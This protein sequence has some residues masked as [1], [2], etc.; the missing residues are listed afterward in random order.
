MEAAPSSVV[1]ISGTV[2]NFLGSCSRIQRVAVAVYSCIL[3]L[4]LFK[5]SY[6]LPN[7]TL[8]QMIIATIDTKSLPSSSLKASTSHNEKNTHNTGTDDDSSDIEEVDPHPAQSVKGWCY[9]GSH[10]FTPSAWGTLSGSAFNPV[11]NVCQFFFFCIQRADNT[12]NIQITNYEIGVIFPLESTEAANNIACWE[13]PPRKYNLPEE[14]AW[15]SGWHPEVVIHWQ[16][17]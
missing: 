1:E 12:M 13:R 14:R 6:V 7:Q 11:L 17:C 8:N 9:I 15:V 16:G 4:E 10:N 5:Y 3:R 2:P